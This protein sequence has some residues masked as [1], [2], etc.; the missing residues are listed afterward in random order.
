MQSV[1]S[2]L[3]NES[4]LV[5]STFA[6]YLLHSQYH[7][8]QVTYFRFLNVSLR[9]SVSFDF[10]SVAT[11]NTAK[12]ER[13]TFTQRL[14]NSTFITPYVEPKF[15]LSNDTTANWTSSCNSN[16]HS[17]R[18][19]L[20]IFCVLQSTQQIQCKLKHGTSLIFHRSGK[21]CCQHVPILSS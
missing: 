14:I 9:E 17:H 10:G 15:L 4:Y 18:I 16:S 21:I 6:F 7:L 20:W 8:N 19:S 11:G 13:N 12:I 1:W 3:C 2:S 5:H